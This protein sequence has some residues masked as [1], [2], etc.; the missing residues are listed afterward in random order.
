[1]L[2]NTCATAIG[3]VSVVWKL[4]SCPCAYSTAA[5]EDSVRVALPTLNL[6]AVTLRRARLSLFVH[7]RKTGALVESIHLGYGNCN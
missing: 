1:M 7:Q 3:G 5:G 2:G 6:E 4:L